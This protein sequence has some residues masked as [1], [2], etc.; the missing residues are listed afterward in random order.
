VSHDDFEEGVAAF[1]GGDH[2]LARRAFAAAAADG[3]ADAQAML[4]YLFEA[5]FGGPRDLSEAATSYR[6]AAGQ[7]H[8]AAAFNL[9]ALLEREGNEQDLVEARA[10][11]LV[12]LRRFFPWPA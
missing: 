3:H 4:G 6:A 2:T 7:G 12:A 11:Y 5:G 1:R 10:W 9:A 8:A